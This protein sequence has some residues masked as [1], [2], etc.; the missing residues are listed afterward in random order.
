MVLVQDDDDYYDDVDSGGGSSGRGCC[1]AIV[2]PA[3][4][5]LVNPLKKIEGKIH[6]RGRMA[7]NI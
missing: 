1:F 2:P 7:K 3:P 6:K 4:L 5:Y